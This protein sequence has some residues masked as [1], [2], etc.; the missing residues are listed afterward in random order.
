[1]KH[2]EKVK[3]ELT[4]SGIDWELG[5]ENGWSENSLT[6]D[7]GYCKILLYVEED[8][9]G[10]LS[11]IY[12]DLFEEGEYSPLFDNTNE[13]TTTSYRGTS[14]SVRSMLLDLDL[15]D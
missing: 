8:E 14:T 3:K 4:K 11:L 10:F 2:L 12:H 5:S 1:M 6:F 13:E 9:D 15:I 7:G